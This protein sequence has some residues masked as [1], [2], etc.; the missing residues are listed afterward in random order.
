MYKL[1]NAKTLSVFFMVLL[2]F[3]CCQP[4]FAQEYKAVWN[5]AES[6]IRK[7][8]NSKAIEVLD[9]AIAEN[10]E[11]GELYYLRGA[12][13]EQKELYKDALSD[14]IKV[15]D[16]SED[17]NIAAA[18]FLSRA[19]LEYLL[20]QNDAADRDY[21]K[22]VEFEPDLPIVHFEYATFLFR[23]QK[24]EDAF[25]HIEKSKKLEKNEK[26]KTRSI[27]IERLLKI[28]TYGNYAKRAI[29]QIQ[30]NNPNKAIYVLTDGIKFNRSDVEL[31]CMRGALMMNTDHFQDAMNDFNQVIKIADKNK[32]KIFLADAY[33]NKA[34]VE[35]KIKKAKEAEADFKLAIENDPRLTMAYVEYAQ[36]LIDRKRPAEA[37][38]YLEKGKEIIKNAASKDLNK[39]IDLLLT[40]AR[41]KGKK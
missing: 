6:L 35:S 40:T 37:I 18:S 36:F 25:L 20:K 13:R 5:K 22:I 31:Y 28:A 27:E 26:L 34:L 16:Y 19:R 2:A 29:E 14:Q 15:M 4:T 23:T 38:P 41:S 12:L 33:M 39:R 24:S 10:P 21:R 32:D 8:E 17:K 11:S 1:F 3:N 30:A 9:K 7:N